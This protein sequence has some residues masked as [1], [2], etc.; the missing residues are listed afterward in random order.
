MVQYYESGSK[1]PQS[2]LDNTCDDLLVEEKFAGFEGT[3]N[4][5]IASTVGI[6]GTAL[7]CDKEGEILDTGNSEVGVLFGT[8]EYML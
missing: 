1:S 7:K 2:S 6:E 4:P 5:P 3:N 8:E